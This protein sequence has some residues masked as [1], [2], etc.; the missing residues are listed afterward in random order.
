MA[1]N[2]SDLRMEEER[3]E[4]IANRMKLLSEP[5]RLRLLERLKNGE[6]CVKE[7]VEETGA[8]QANVSKH[9]ALLSVHGVVDKRKEGLY[10]YYRLKDMSVLKMLDCLGDQVDA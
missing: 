3:I 6:R 10:V 5:M 1:N 7:L 9:L 2:Y 8:G 4:K